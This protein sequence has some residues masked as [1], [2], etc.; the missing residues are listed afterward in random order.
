MDSDATPPQHVPQHVAIIPDGNRRWAKERGLPAAAG[1]MEGYARIK[2]LIRSARDEG[3][4]YLTLWA[5]STENW[6][7][8]KDEVNQ[9]SLLIA[10]GLEELH[11]EALQEKTKVVHLG[12]KDRL[13]P[14]I[15]K[16]IEAIEED[17]KDFSDFCI[18][19]AVDYGGHDEVERATQEMLARGDSEIFS[20]LDTRRLNIPDPDLIIRTSGEKRTSGFMPLQGA[21]AEWIFDERNF[22][23]FTKE[24]FREAL[25]EYAKRNRRFGV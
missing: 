3:V 5:F 9:L 17:T 6:S 10:H 25:A 20:Y 16:A 1:H 23:D 18:C 15:Q 14:R 21:Y 24:C 8:S 12:R 4:L 2:E 13:S 19:M 22:P 11:K 7:R